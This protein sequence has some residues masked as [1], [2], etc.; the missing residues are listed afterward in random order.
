MSHMLPE[1]RQEEFRKLREIV[2]NPDFKTAQDVEIFFTA[3]TKYIWE[4]KMI[5]KI[6][7]F[8]TDDI[9]IYKENDENL[10]G[11]EFEFQYT[12]EFISAFPDLKVT[13]LCMMAEKT[14]E[15]EFKFVQ[16][17]HLDATSTGPTSA[18]PATGKKLNYSNQLDIC[19][20]LLKKVNGQWR[21]VGEWVVDSKK[22]VDSVLK[23][24]DF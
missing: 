1:K 6:Y 20:C 14:G 2:E 22:R 19:E 7:D 21:I 11:V 16:V 15:E 8:Y 5:G 17:T 24:Y 10:N 12:K 23:G 3:L 18:G 4:H 9:I 13:F